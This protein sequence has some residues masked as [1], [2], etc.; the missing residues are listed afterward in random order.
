MS[1]AH[2]ANPG[3]LEKRVADAVT[4]RCLSSI[5]GMA[6]NA[7]QWTCTI[8]YSAARSL[9]GHEAVDADAL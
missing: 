5:I 1:Q 3:Q 8:N 6:M 9:G 2:L 7:K 4:I